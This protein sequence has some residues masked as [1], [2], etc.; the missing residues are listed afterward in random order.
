MV[1]VVTVALRAFSLIYKSIPIE[2]QPLLLEGAKTLT[3]GGQTVGAHLERV[4]DLTPND[5]D[6]EVV[7]ALLGRLDRMQKQLDE[8]NKPDTL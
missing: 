3:R 5:F 6:N 7:K 4:A 1:G 2:L 8:L